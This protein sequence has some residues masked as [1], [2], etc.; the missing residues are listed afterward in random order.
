MLKRSQKLFRWARERRR[1]SESFSEPSYFHQ[2]AQK[3]NPVS[4]N[5]GV[6]HA[7]DD[8]RRRGL[9]LF[10]Q[11][12]VLRPNRFGWPKLKS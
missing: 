2:A 10:W 4:R 1:S 3:W 8:A 12:L 5:A 7:G 6:P 11:K 9:P